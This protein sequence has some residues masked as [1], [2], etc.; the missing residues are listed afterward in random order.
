MRVAKK[1]K[2]D[3]RNTSELM[4]PIAATV[5]NHLRCGT[6]LNLSIAVLQ[7]SAS[8]IHGTGLGLPIAKSLAEA[9]DGRLSVTSGVG[10]GSVFTLSL[11]VIEESNALQEKQEGVRVQ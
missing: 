5:L 11:P 4:F 10:V 8:Q 3:T 6:S 2:D 9:M 1:R 7:R